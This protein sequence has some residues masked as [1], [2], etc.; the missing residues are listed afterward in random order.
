MTIETPDGKKKDLSF[1]YCVIAT[2]SAQ[3]APHK[4]FESKTPEVRKAKIKSEVERLT[5][6]KSAL[7]VGGGV[8]GVEIAC[9]LADKMQERG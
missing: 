6:T 9:E 4:D 1:D 2:G 5:T 3:P 8:V 7:I